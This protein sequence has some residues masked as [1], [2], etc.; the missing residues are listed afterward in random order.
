MTHDIYSVVI[1]RI[2]RQSNPPILR[3]N[4]PCYE[5]TRVWSVNDLIQHTIIGNL[6]YVTNF[7]QIWPFYEI[8]KSW[9]VFTKHLRFLF[10]NIGLL[11]YFYV[12]HTVVLHL[13]IHCLSH[14]RQT[15]TEIIH[16]IHPVLFH[17][18]RERF[19]WAYFIA[20]PLFRLLLYLFL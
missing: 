13:C 4:S 20:C 2:T 8:Y 10:P 6:N 11:F 16:Q 19:Q 15:L 14:V 5:F 3:L 7:T 17:T 1:T 9:N 18:Y 12:F